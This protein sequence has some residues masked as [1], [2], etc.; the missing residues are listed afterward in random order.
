VYIFF[1]IFLYKQVYY[2]KKYAM[3]VT[4]VTYFSYQTEPSS[5]N[6][7]SWGRLQ[8]AMQVD[9]YKCKISVCIGVIPYL[10]RIIKIVFKI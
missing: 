5:D 2:Q 3:G 6:H 1:A 9:K 8:R 4:A 10:H 7:S